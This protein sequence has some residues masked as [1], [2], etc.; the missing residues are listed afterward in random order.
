VSCF[1]CIW[2]LLIAPEAP[3]PLPPLFIEL[4]PAPPAAGVLPPVGGPFCATAGSGAN[5]QRG[6][7]CQRFETC[8]ISPDFVRVIALMR[9]STTRNETPRS[10]IVAESTPNS[11]ETEPS[12]KLPVVSAN[13]DSSA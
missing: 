2:Y 6:G 3:A 11:K 4:F 9:R 13:H 12:A 5:H 8:H 7:Y 10:K 1:F